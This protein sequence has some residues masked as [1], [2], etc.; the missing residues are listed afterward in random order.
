[1]MHNKSITQCLTCLLLS[2]VCKVNGS[3]PQIIQ[4]YTEQLNP[5]FIRDGFPTGLDI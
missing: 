4:V 1:M 5:V 3:E 2:L